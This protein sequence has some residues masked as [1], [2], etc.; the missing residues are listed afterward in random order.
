MARQG[1]HTLMEAKQVPE[2][3]ASLTDH[4]ALPFCFA[5]AIPVFDWLIPPLGFSSTCVSA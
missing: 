5:T 3:A 1:A 2:C 4:R